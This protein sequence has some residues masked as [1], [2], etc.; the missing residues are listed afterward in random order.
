LFKLNDWQSLRQQLAQVI[1]QPGLLQKLKENIKPERT[2]QDMVN[3]IESVYS[4]M[5]GSK[6]SV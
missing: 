4:T 1:S 2:V 5:A 3:D 6:V